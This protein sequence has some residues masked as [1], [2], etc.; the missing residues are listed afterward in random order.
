[1][2]FGKLI[3]IGASAGGI[4][5]IQKLLRTVPDDC[6]LP[7]VAVQ[8]IG[9]DHEF[10]PNLIFSNDYHGKVGE[11]L[12]KT[13]IEPGTLYCAPPGYHLLL[14]R[15]ASLS[16]SQDEKVCFSRPSIDV[17]FESVAAAF[18]PDQYVGV[19]L[20]GANR[21]GSEG[22]KRMEE[23]GAKT[24]V[25]NPQEA[26]FPYMPES[27]IRILTRPQVLKIENIMESI[28]SSSKEQN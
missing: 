15:D 18:K 14:E 1:M 20:T 17:F 23:A 5:A 28:I 13:L 12:D 4:I 11:V 2:K 8:H 26:D 16:L 25:Q 22:L 21:D 27:A 3:C 7:I 24:I 6:S 9:G 19:L 10:D